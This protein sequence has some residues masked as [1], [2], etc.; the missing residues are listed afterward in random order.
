MDNKRWWEI[1]LMPLVIAVLGSGATFFITKTQIDSS[2]KIALAERDS[3]ER[4]AAAERDSAEK[5]A[6]LDRQLKLLEIFNAKITSGNVREAQ[7]AIQL[8]QL[9][10]PDVAAQLAKA[11]ASDQSADPGVRQ[12]AVRV[13]EQAQRGNAFPVVRSLSDLNSAIQFARKISGVVPEYTVEIYK[14]E[15]GDYYAVTL[16]GYLRLE[17]ALKRVKIARDREIAPDAFVWQST[18][19]GENLLK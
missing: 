14:T 19:W 18:Q 2:E 3:A 9:V 1:I 16:G 5:R 15:N 7:L 4:R 6:R 12:Q 17:E 13:A 10:D 11:V 8:L